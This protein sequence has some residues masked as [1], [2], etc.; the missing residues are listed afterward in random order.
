MVMYPEIL[1]Q[2]PPG[3]ALCWRWRIRRQKMTELD[4]ARHQVP[5]PKTPSRQLVHE[6]GGPGTVLQQMSS[7]R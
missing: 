4:G 2:L 6:V 7:H 3:A 1:A 5:G